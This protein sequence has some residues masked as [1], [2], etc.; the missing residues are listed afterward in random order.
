L[1]LDP[2]HPVL[3]ATLAVALYTLPLAFLAIPAPAVVTAFAALLAGAGLA[4]ATTCGRRPSSVT[5][6]PSCSRA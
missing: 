1:Q 3:V 4:V 2:R 6:R 5:C